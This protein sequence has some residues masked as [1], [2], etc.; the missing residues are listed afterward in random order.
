VRVKRAAPKML[1]MVGSSDSTGTLS[2]GPPVPS[3]FFQA[4]PIRSTNRHAHVRVRM[5]RRRRIT[6][7]R[8]TA[9]RSLNELKSGLGFS[10]DLRK[11]GQ[12]ELVLRGARRSASGIRLD[13]KQPLPLG[14]RLG[15]RRAFWSRGVRR[16]PTCSTK[17][18]Q[19]AERVEPE[20]RSKQ[21]RESR[22]EQPARLREAFFPSRR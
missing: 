13:L 7:S 12:L 3:F 4:S 6:G 15:G 9:Q 8:L 18:R 14:R 10:L 11:Q 17:L 2:A 19:L 1:R 20:R 5:R 21:E 16:S 22:Q